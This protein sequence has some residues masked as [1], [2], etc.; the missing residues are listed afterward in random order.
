MFCVFFIFCSDTTLY[1]ASN[2][3]FCISLYNMYTTSFS[4]LCMGR[5]DVLVLEQ[6]NTLV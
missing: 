2:L 4:L 3:L 5:S 6:N 1:F